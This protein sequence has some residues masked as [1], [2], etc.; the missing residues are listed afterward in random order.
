MRTSK[1]FAALT[2]AT[3]IASGVMAQEFPR[4]DV[5]LGNNVVDISNL[6]IDF[7]ITFT[8]NQSFWASAPGANRYANFS[9]RFKYDPTK[10]DLQIRR[11]VSGDN[12]I[13]V[14]SLP[15]GTTGSGLQDQDIFFVAMPGLTGQ[16]AFQRLS[17]DGKVVV[18]LGLGNSTNINTILSGPFLGSLVGGSFVPMRWYVHGLAVGET[19][20]VET[21]IGFSGENGQIVKTNPS[22]TS[23]FNNP[24]GSWEVVPE[25]ASMIALGSGLVGLLALRRRR[26]N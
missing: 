11:D 5:T 20:N 15:N 24:Q 19:Y 22:R 1:L 23:K 14:S 2:A 25:P 8:P 7:S 21:A 12:W 9:L 26:S 13:S 10:V 6:Y 17:Q 3:V 16:G 18:E 4:S